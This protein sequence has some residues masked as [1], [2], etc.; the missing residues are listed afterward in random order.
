[1]S[2]NPLDIQ[3]VLVVALNYQSA[4]QTA[5]PNVTYQLGHILFDH[6]YAV[7]GA[8]DP[9]NTCGGFEKPMCFT[10]WGGYNVHGDCL[11]ANQAT[12][13]S[14]IRLDGTEVPFGAGRSIL[15]RSGSTRASRRATWRRRRTRRR[16]ARSGP[17][18]AS[19]SLPCVAPG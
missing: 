13:G 16:G 8:G 3:Q 18:T 14:Y 5:D 19:P 7:Q 12:H 9:P 4:P 1:M 10:P 11:P 17:S 2:Y 6:T 15:R